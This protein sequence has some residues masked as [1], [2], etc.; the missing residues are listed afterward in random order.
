ME[1]MGTGT[2]EALLEEGTPV[3]LSPGL[4]GSPAFDE[5]MARAFIDIGVDLLNDGAAAIVRA[6]AKHETGD[7]A[8]AAAAAAEVRMG[9]KIEFAAKKGSLLC[10]KKYA[11]KTEYAPEMMVAGAFV[12]WAGQ[13]GMTIKVQREKGAELRK[14]RKQ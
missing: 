9:P 3:P 7:D 6:I 1:E 14:E 8:A 4:E 13:I 5:E 2:P 11:V 10:A 12:L